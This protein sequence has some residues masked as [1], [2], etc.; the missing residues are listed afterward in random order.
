MGCSLCHPDQI[1]GPLRTLLEVIRKVRFRWPNSTII[2]KD[3]MSVKSILLMGL[4]LVSVSISAQDPNFHIYL[5]FGQSNMEGF[6]GIPEEEKTGVGDR[7][8]VLA[9]VDFESLNR[10]QGKWY[11]AVPPL[12]RPR[13]GMSPADYFG[14]TLVTHLPE[15]IKI[16]VI[17]VA[18]G[19]CKIELYEKDTYESYVETAP[20]WMQTAIA[21]YGGNPY[22]RL[23]DLAQQAQKLGVIK[24]VLLHQGESNTNDE[25]WP[26]KVKGVYENLLIDLNLRAEHVP[27]LVGEVVHEDQQGRCAS[28]NAIIGKLPKILQTAHV[29]SSAGCEAGRDRLHFTPNGYREL[30]RRYANTMLQLLGYESARHGAST[31]RSQTTRLPSP[32]DRQVVVSSSSKLKVLVFS[33][34]G[35]FRHP[36]IPKINRWL[37]LLGH[38]HGFEVDV[39]ENGAD[40]RRRTLDSYDVLVL[41]NANEL[42]SILS[43]Q[44][45]ES[46][47]QW[48]MQE[49][50][51]IVGLH[52]ALVHQTNWPWFLN[53]AGADFNSDSEY[54]RAKVMVDPTALDHPTIKG[55]PKEFWI[56]ADWTNHDRNVT[57]IPGFE[58]LLRVDEST[59]TPVREFF[60]SRG[61]KPMGDH[62]IAWT[63]EP[64]S[65]G[66]F[67]Y[68]EFGHDMRSLSTPFVH[69]H[70]LEGIRWAAGVVSSAQ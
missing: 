67:F 30:G 7:F 29:I 57:G 22:G 69:Q 60:Q 40:L 62:P 14:R 17:N 53:L 43:Q 19:G 11:T 47:E 26:N 12:S 15:T 35:W 33:G 38:E 36:D 65:G 44:Q 24:G 27:L 20:D 45:R 13:A 34:T 39:T 16:G 2:R 58:V 70:I 54:T 63:N 48:F 49:K 55:Q 66:R 59:Y 23:V 51:G 42:D 50:K 28:M 8:Q 31:A 37:V 41:N 9:A 46:V 52:A 21:A 68:T 64:S 56:E 32:Q 5:C 18:V 6:P 3:N 25:E 10:E 61:G 4:T 1:G